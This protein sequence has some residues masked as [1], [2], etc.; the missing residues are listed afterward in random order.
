MG[1]VGLVGWGFLSFLVWGF[2]GFVYIFVGLEDRKG[3]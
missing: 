1:G 3:L 2:E